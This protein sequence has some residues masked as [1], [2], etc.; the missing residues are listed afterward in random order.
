MT[1]A[2]VAWSQGE[3]GRMEKMALIGT[4]RY[5]RGGDVWARQ[6]AG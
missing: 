5:I 1:R 3:I 4:D 6:F 2:L